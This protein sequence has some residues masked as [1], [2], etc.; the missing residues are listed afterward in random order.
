MKLQNLYLVKIYRVLLLIS[1]ILPALNLFAQDKP[2]ELDTVTIKD[3]R[4]RKEAGL[5]KIDPTNAVNIPSPVQGIESLIKIFVGSNNELTS[6]YSVRG[7]NYDENL[8]YVN[9]FEVFRPYLVRS[10]QQEG[11][12]FINPELTRNVNFYNGGFQSRYGDKMS[13]VLDVQYKKP[14]TFAGSVYLGLL[15]QGLHLEGISK[16]KKFTYLTG[17]RNR[18]NRNLL[19]SQETQGNYIPSSADLQALL[20]YNFNETSVLELMGNI[21]RTKFTLEPEFSQLSSSVFSPYFSANLGLDTY[22]EGREEDNYKTNMAGLS[23]THQPKK[24]LR[25]KWMT[26]FFNDDER[27]SID[28]T[29]AYLFGSREFDKSKPDYGLIT[30]PMGAG[31]YQNFARNKLRINVWNASHKGSLDKGRHFIQ[32]GQSVDLQSIKDKLHEWNYSDSAGYNIPYNPDMIVMSRYVDSRADLDI[33]RL[34]G[35]IQDNFLINDAFTVQGGVRYNY[36]NLNN[37]F[38]VSPRLNF[39][40]TPQRWKSDIIF[41]GA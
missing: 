38:L 8:I 17:V 34:S 39:S 40:W 3:K 29:G 19:S 15:E 24:N 26:S 32:W 23:F 11:L 37:E 36:N 9:D 12:S 27:E 25:L 20:T 7:G 35:Y 1:F 31:L 21:S 5:I 30:S 4:G 14:T 28:I 13:S 6:Q 33:L 2:K 18:S 22:F 16:N 41:R 10:G